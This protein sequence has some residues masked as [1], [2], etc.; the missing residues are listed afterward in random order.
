MCSAT[1]DRPRSGKAVKC[2]LSAACKDFPMNV[3]RLIR[4][5]R[6]K[7]MEARGSVPSERDRRYD[8]A[9]AGLTG[10]G[11]RLLIGTDESGRAIVTN[12]PATL[13]ELLRTFCTLNAANE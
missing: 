3:Q 4:R 8:D 9:L 2:E 7:A 13:P 12:F 11:G 10:P 6:P 5:A 1:G